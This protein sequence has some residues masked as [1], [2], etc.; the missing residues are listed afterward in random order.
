[1]VVV[2]NIEIVGESEKGWEDAVKN[3]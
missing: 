1:M 2:K 3:A